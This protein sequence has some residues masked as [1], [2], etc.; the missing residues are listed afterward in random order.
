MHFPPT[1]NGPLAAAGLAVWLVL[2]APAWAADFTSDRIAVETTGE[3]PDVILV[4]GLNSS[5]AV[6]DDLTATLEGYRFHLVQVNGFAGL[7][8]G[9]NAEGP[10]VAPVAEEIARYIDEEGLEAP[11][12]IG[13]SMGGTVSVLVAARF[14]DAVGRLMVVD[15][16][17]F[18]G[19]IMGATPET[20]T[21]M[22]ES[23]KAETL[24]LGEDAR[25][26]RETAMI[27]AGVH[28]EAARRLVIEDM[29]AS[30]PVVAAEAM[31]DITVTDLRPE[32]AAITAPTTVVFVTPAGAPGMTREQVE[33]FYAMEY[34][35][36]RDLTL[37]FV[38][39]SG[40]YVM[41]DK[42]EVFAALVENFL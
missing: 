24:S 20:A 39:G 9:A 12:L 11:A 5:P 41:L 18:M 22:A 35:G 36:V 14:P 31:Y 19:G 3:G 23:M 2:A 27:T 33:G 10:V 32:L 40:H 4:P 17:A 1:L 30:D 29:L 34:G 7:P 26:A 42:P 16:P 28:D 6:W 37:E 15:V 25:V 21:A 13:H 38:A 8:A